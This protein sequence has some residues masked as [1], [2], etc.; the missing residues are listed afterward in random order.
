MNE[1]TKRLIEMAIAI[2]QVPA[3]TFLEE[4]RAEFVRSRLAEEGLR[5]ISVDNVHN[6]YAR[7]PGRDASLPALVV[8]AHLDTVFPAETELRLTRDAERIHGPG[9]GDNSFGVAALFGLLWSLRERGLQLPGD[10]WLV[11]NAGEEGLGDLR[12]MKAVVERFQ[13][14]P[15]AYLVLEGMAF[16]H[17]YH[18]AIA[19]HRYR[20][21]VTTAGG[22]AWSDYGQPSAV[23]ELT[24]LASQ[25]AVFELPIHPRTTLN[26]GRIEG[27]TGVN[28]LASHASLDLDMRS[29]DPAVLAELVARVDALI[30]GANR[31]GV[32]VETESIGQRPG[33]QIPATHPLVLAAVESFRELGVD[34]H[35]I[36]GSTDANVP[37]SKGHPSVVM[38][39]TSGGGAHT[40]KEFVNIEP[41]ETGMEAIVRMVEKIFKI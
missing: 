28:V 37:L 15:R 19:V 31:S 18:R 41:I 14:R 1:A 11:G 10:V 2:Q 39:V 4:K 25:I 34:P 12:G 16:G 13:D 38:G 32:K 7:L 24:A 30:A 6:V 8:S 40:L 23:H 35:L 26:V 29:E 27:G 3:P 21:S 22:H 17:I 33:G 9:I 36:G 5:D 20:I